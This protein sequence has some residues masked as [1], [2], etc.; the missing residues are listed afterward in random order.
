MLIQ[1]HIPDTEVQ[2]RLI[3]LNYTTEIV[4]V[5]TFSKGHHNRDEFD[6]INELQVVH[7][8]GV[9]VPAKEFLENLL[10]GAI[11]DMLSKYNETVKILPD[12]TN[13]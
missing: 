4:Q 12:E 5:P 9:K 2:R 8:N 13:N 1:L 7:A 11:T 3:A 10:D 6:T